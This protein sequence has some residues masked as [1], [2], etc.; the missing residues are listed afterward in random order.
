[1]AQVVL[2][3]DRDA[4]SEADA[5]LWAD[6]AAFLLW[7]EGAGAIVIANELKV[8]FLVSA[9]CSFQRRIP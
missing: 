7:C 9:Y 6:D 4:T 3:L 1:M 8:I 2:D 5:R